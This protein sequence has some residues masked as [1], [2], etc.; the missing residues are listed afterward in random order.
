MGVLDTARRNG[1]VDGVLGGN[2]RWLVL[3]SI[4]WG[5]RAVGWAVARDERVLFRDRL[6]PGEQLVIS[7]RQA[8]PKRRG[9]KRQKQ[10]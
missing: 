10:V 2:K 4:A 8:V 6:R 7:E 9:K 3:G 5:I 1:L